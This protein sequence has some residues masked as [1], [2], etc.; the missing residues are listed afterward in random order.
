MGRPRKIEFIERDVHFLN[1]E[2]DTVRHPLVS[3]Q[4]LFPS[5]CDFRSIQASQ[6]PGFLGR[7]D[8]VGPACF[9]VHEGG[10]HDAVVH[11]LEGT[12]PELH[13]CDMGYG[14]ACASVHFNEHDELLDLLAACGFI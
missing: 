1:P 4:L 11:E 10:G 3:F 5:V 2:Q 12:P 7:D 9:Q 8:P 14:I 6:V 13:A